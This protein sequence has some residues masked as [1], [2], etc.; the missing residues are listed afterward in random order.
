MYCTYYCSLNR[1]GMSRL[2]VLSSSDTYAQHQRCICQSHL[3]YSDGRC[4]SDLVV[5]C[6][7][8]T[9]RRFI[10]FANTR[11]KVGFDGAVQCYWEK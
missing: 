5:G 9:D 1:R 3:D 4:F 6:K 8:N 11:G 7:I 10:E 2:N